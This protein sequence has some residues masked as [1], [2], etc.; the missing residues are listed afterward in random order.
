[1]EVLEIVGIVE[2]EWNSN[3][4]NH[5]PMPF[6]ITQPFLP[7]VP[8]HLSSYSNASHVD[9]SLEIFGTFIALTL[10]SMHPVDFKALS[11]TQAPHEDL[12]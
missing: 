5:Y 4:L 9:F 11:F 1:M 7:P 3:L 2:V 12:H 10:P 6:T 8:A